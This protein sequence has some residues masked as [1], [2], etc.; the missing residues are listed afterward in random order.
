MTKAVLI[1]EVLHYV[2]CPHC[3][4]SKSK[5][6]HLFGH[7]DAKKTWGPW[8]CDECGGEYRGY[9]VGEDVFVEKLNGRIDYSIVFLKNNNVLLAVKGMYFNGDHDI[10]HDEYF[11]EEHTCPTNYFG[12]V[13]M[14]VNLE[15]GDTDPHG[16]FEFIG[17]IP[18][19]NLD[20]VENI[21][22]LLA[23]LMKN[24]I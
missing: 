20:E 3:H 15:N 21:Q 16:I 5:V 11:Y 24:K 22:S 4:N 9:V 13:E 19:V 2:E 7:T 17:S 6:D 23:P 14:V 1:T 12:N 10:G 8:Y 18:Y